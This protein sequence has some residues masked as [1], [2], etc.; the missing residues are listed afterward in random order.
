MCQR[1]L[2][3]KVGF[4]K[5]STMESTKTIWMN[6][7]LT[8]WDEANVHVLTHSF[9]YGGASFE[10]IRCYK[11][12]KGTAVFRLKEHMERLFYSAEA[13]GMEV[14]YSVDEMTEAVLEVL[15]ENELEEG[16]IRPMIYYGYGKMGL[17]PK[18]ASVDAFIACWGWA[19]YLA[20][21]AVKVK[22]SDF[23]RIHPKSTVAD[24][25]ITGHYV[26]SSLASMALE[27]TGAHE[28]LLLDFEGNVAEGPGENIFVVKD[29]VLTT[30][31]LGNILAGLTRDTVMTLAKDMGYEVQEKVLKPEDLFAADEAFFTGTAAEVTAISSID[32]HVYGDGN[33]GPVSAK[34]KEAY[35][36]V[37]H[38]K[39]DRYEDYLTYI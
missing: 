33:P 34:L 29:E 14:P 37:V 12:E 3:Q 36:N 32:D 8:P 1:K 35:M 6:G 5:S 15:R 4:L 9:H 24:A 2:A 18:G 13:L 28:A 17:N 26:N 10:G 30:P 20:H 31:A 7:K 21:D 11:T 23:I 27:G 19:K 38:G 25:K 16:Y 22:I 39:D